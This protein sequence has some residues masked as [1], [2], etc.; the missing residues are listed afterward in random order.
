LELVGNAPTSRCATSEEWI[1]IDSK[2]A[3]R[4]ADD[5]A[6]ASALA[7]LEAAG[8][9]NMQSKLSVTS[10]ASGCITLGG[11]GCLY[12][13]GTE[14]LLEG[15]LR[16]ARVGLGTSEVDCNVTEDHV[17]TLHGKAVFSPLSSSM[18]T[19]DTLVDLAGNQVCS[20]KRLGVSESE[21]TID[22]SRAFHVARDADRK[23]ALIELARSGAV[24]DGGR[25]GVSGETITIDSAF[26][27]KVTDSAARL[28]KFMALARQ[29]A[30]A[31][32][33]ANGPRLVR[34]AE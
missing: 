29:G 33:V 2:R 21:I 17:I 18:N 19:V 14:R 9:C 10:D 1:T 6:R 23:D 28:E 12:A 26:V 13:L 15:M 5:G 7:A 30:C 8:A 27:E 16:M 3:L 22:L 31:G 34:G 24:E 32:S 25:C 4:F 20:K 11:K